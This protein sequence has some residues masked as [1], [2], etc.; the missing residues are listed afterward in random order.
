ML[1]MCEGAGPAAEKAMIFARDV[2]S[3]QPYRFTGLIAVSTD[4]IRAQQRSCRFFE[5]YGRGIHA[6]PVHREHAVD[7]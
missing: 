7:L 2:L 1:T 6:D 3:D 4:P 5:R